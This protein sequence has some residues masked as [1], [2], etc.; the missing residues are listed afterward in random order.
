MSAPWV[1]GARATRFAVLLLE[2]QRVVYAYPED[3]KKASEV[4]LKDTNA[5]GALAVKK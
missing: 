1:C 4:R 3:Q 2:G 5:K